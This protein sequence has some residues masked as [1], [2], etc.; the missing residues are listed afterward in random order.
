MS[1][2]MRFREATMSDRS[3]VEKL[4]R[5]AYAARVRGDIETIGRI[6]ADNA[7]FE[8]AGSSQ[9]SAIPARV[10][11]AGQ[12]RPL[13]S[14]MIKTFE[15]SDLRIL[16][17]VIEGSKAAVHW[18]VKVRSSVTGETADTQ[19]MDFIEVK[20]GRITSFVE[21]CDTALASRL[22]GQSL[23]RSG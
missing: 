12:I 13:I 2:K 17:M 19:L 7:R 5:E 23:A 16:S 3:S 22:M 1:C 20:D 11:G 10:D 21:F 18:R 8:V 6:F 14:Q 9:V 15:M 4:L